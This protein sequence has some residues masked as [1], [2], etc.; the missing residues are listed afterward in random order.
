M[1]SVLCV[2]SLLL[3][4]SA[5][6]AQQSKETMLEI[7]SPFSKQVVHHLRFGTSSDH[8]ELA[9]AY[10]VGEGLQKDLGKAAAWYKKAADRGHT[11]AMT[12]LGRMYCEG[13]GVPQDYQRAF[14]WFQRGAMFGD[15]QAQFNLGLM[16]FHGLGVARDQHR[17]SATTFRAR[18]T[19]RPVIIFDA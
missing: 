16:Y 17:A 4:T 1:R 6:I 13:L 19:N 15:P 2:S 9:H 10:L 18:R 12:E 3:M 5:C 11:G 7:G 14:K 8:F